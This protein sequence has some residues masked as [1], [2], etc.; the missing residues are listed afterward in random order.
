MDMSL[1]TLRVEQD[2]LSA[3]I[4]VFFNEDFSYTCA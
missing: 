1:I 4:K 3:V 2:L